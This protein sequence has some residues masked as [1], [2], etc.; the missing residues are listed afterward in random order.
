MK[1]RLCLLALFLLVLL[2]TSHVGVEAKKKKGKGKG[3]GKGKSPSSS[4]PS[5]AS[6]AFTASEVAAHSS[7]GNGWL[8][9]GSSVYDVSKFR[10]PGGSIINSVLGRD[11]TSEFKANHNAKALGKMKKYRIGKKA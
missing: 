2:T 11:A 8:V 3:K 6:S 1:L 5:S 10:H 4:A 9:V 7:P